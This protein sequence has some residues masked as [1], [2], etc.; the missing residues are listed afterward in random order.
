MRFS[1]TALSTF[2]QNVNINQTNFNM[3][4]PAIYIILMIICIFTTSM[5]TT[6]LISSYYNKKEVEKQ[7]VEMEHFLEDWNKKNNQLNESSMRP[8]DAN[9][10]DKVQTDILFRLQVFNLNLTSV[11]ELK[12]QENN[13]R[14]YVIE[15]S[16]PYEN[17]MKFIH[18]IQN[19]DAL[20]GLKHLIISAKDGGI[21]IKLTYKIYTK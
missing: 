4:K 6:S 10:I 5:L 20:V 9:I 12:Q 21:Q 17:V 7:I 11:K 19:T 18:S 16:G 14:V 15:L 8:V 2:F 3:H 13:G 1:K